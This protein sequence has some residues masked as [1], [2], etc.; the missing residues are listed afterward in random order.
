MAFS[1]PQTVTVATVA[2]TLN[3]TP[4]LDGNAQGSFVKDDQ[5]YKLE[6]TQ[7]KKG[8]TSHIVRLS[9][10]KIAADPLTSANNVE[11]QMSV[12]VS[13]NAPNV[14]YTATEQKDLIAAI[15]AWLT[16]STNANA[17]KLVNFEA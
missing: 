13:V 3:R 14:G 9:A 1:D 12:T 4:V 5:S 15:C 8:R 11:Y 7:S 6:V 2:Q 16:A 17:I 10:R